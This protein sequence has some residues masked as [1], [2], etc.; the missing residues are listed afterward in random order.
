MLFRK[1]RSAFHLRKVHEY[2]EEV[3]FRSALDTL[4]KVVVSNENEEEVVTLRILCYIEL[5]ELDIALNEISYYCL[6]KYSEKNY[7][8]TNTLS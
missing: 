4:R 7:H 8:D 2:L 3:D 1:F 5:G 6:Y